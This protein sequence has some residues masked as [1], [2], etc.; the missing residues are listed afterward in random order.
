VFYSQDFGAGT[1]IGAAL[2]AS[3][4]P[5]YTYNSNNFTV[6]GQYTIIQNPRNGLI[7]GS[8]GPWLNGTDHTGNA[9][10]RMLLVNGSSPGQI[11]YNQPVTGLVIGRTYAVRTFIANVINGTTGSFP[12]LPNINFYI[13]DAANNTLATTSTGDI[14]ISPTLTWLQREMSFVAT[15]TSVTFQLVSNNTSGN[16]NDFALDDITFYEKVEPLLSSTSTTV[17]CPAKTANVSSVTVSNLP[18]GARLSWHTSTPATAAN[19]ITNISALTAGTYYVAFTDGLCYSN[20]TPFIVNTVFCP[21]PTVSVSSSAPITCSG[22]NV[23]LTA[24][25]TGLYPTCQLQWQ[26]SADGVSWASISGANTSTYIITA[27]TA[28]MRYRAIVVCPDDKC[29]N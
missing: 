3:Q 7:I 9:N 6:D 4:I 16:G 25:T 8:G 12:L 18:T 26:N 1:G 2:P 11:A 29:C 27:L 15:T 28:T 13:K 20:P 23:T 19:E 17:T 22:G 5:S 21:C 24:T 10:G 14:P